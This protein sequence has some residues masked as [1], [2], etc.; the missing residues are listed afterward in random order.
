MYIYMDCNYNVA[1]KSRTTFFKPCLPHPPLQAMFFPSLLLLAAPNFRVVVY[2]NAEFIE[3]SNVQISSHNLL[4]QRDPQNSVLPQNFP[5]FDLNVP[6]QS[7]SSIDEDSVSPGQAPITD[8]TNQDVN[9]N[10]VSPDL[11][12]QA[13]AAGPTRTNGKLRRG[14]SC[15]IRTPPVQPKTP[16]GKQGV[17]ED[18]TPPGPPPAPPKPLPLLIDKETGQIELDLGP[19]F[20]P[21]LKY[22][23]NGP[24]ALRNLL[25]CTGKLPYPSGSVEN[26]WRCMSW[27]LRKGNV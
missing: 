25:C 9:Q 8:Y 22:Q 16:E 11:Q 24:C 26:C 17:L 13:C 3:G 15:A 2:P 5:T 7:P 1:P 18:I 23:L 21:P 19:E 4:K 27:V 14:L 10:L 20:A 12:A 6:E